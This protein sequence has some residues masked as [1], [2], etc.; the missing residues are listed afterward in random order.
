[1]MTI[2][3]TTNLDE[4]RRQLARYENTVALPQRNV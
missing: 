1:M 4:V 2:N 3:I